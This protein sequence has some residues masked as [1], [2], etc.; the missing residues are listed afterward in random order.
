[1]ERL[2]IATRNRRLILW[3]DGPRTI[4]KSEYPRFQ[5]FYGTT[6]DAEK[7]YVAEHRKGGPSVVLVFDKELNLQGHLPVQLEDPHQVFWWDGMLYIPEPGHDVVLLWNGNGIRRVGWKK[8]NEPNM[9]LNSVWCDGEKF[10]VVEHRWTKMPKRIRVLNLRF[11]PIDCITITK[12]DFIGPPPFIGMHNVYVENGLLYACSPRALVRHNLASGRSNPIVLHPLMDA[13][14][15]AI[16]L[17]R[18]PGKFFVGLSE[19]KPRAERGTG[20]SAVLVTDDNLRVLDILSLKD[21]GTLYEI[22]AIDGPDL[23]HNGMRCPFQ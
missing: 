20:D 8:P 15:C 19:L 17:A 22:R 6:W 10:Y 2:L 23:A 4:Y 11:K 12:K 7:I 9:H 5:K 1:M 21:T 16:G 13:S 14:H 3:D 18:V